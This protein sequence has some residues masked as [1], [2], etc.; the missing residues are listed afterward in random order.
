MNEITYHIEGMTCMGCVKGVE[1][2]LMSVDEIQSAAVDLKSGEAKIT[3]SSMTL[4]LD[5]LQETLGSKYQISLPKMYREVSEGTL[6]KWTQL[7]PLFIIF[8]YLLV[9]SVLLHWETPDYNAMM[10]DFMG[11]FY[12]VFSFF[13]F[14]DLKGFHASF[15]MYDPLAKRL[16]VY[17]W[18]Y[19]FLE[20][21]LGLCFLMR[22]Q[23]NW[24]LVLTLLILG[25]TT[26][27]VVRVL[28]QKRQIQCACLGTALK[29]P[30]TEAT[31]IENAVMIAMALFMLS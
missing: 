21:A 11:L 7:K 26:I 25:V 14:L 4:S 22:F 27:G 1:Q 6:S 13:K 28:L 19:P 23:L 31:F 29:L 9:T 5:V 30:M 12:V 20:L 24:A 10:L 16:S 17:G 15:Q 3:V 18:V 2:K 8:G